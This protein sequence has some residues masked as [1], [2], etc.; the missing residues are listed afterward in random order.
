MA[1]ISY[2]PCN[3]NPANI[4]WPNV[5]VLFLVYISLLSF[6]KPGSEPPHAVQNIELLPVFREVDVPIWQLVL[7]TN[8]D[9][10][11]ILEN[12]TSGEGKDLGANNWGHELSQ[13]FR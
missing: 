8:V 3:C 7:I 10:G 1:K 12:K 4:F 2:N 6:Y 9:E 11:Q 5:R 13:V